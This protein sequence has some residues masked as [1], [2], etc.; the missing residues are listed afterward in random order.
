MELNIFETEISSELRSEF[1]LF[2]DWAEQ[3]RSDDP[4]ARFLVCHWLEKDTK[5]NHEVWELFP[6]EAISLFREYVNEHRGVL[7]DSGT[8]D[9]T[10]LF[11]NRNLG[12]LTQ[13]SLLDLVS[14]ISV[15][16]MKKRMT[17]KH[18]RDLV[19]AHML[20]GGASVDQVAA[21]LWH[22]DTS[23]TTVRYYIG[24]YNTSHAAAELE[25]ALPA[26]AA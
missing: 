3:L 24:G 9:S 19:A 17:V 20:E 7:L 4:E 23:S 10:L 15:R 2:P 16:F 5:A 26:L 21:L 1:K 6:R 14:R 13:K 25:D 12:R 11:F 18:F 22:L 8:A